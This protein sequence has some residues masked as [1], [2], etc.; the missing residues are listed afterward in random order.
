MRALRLPALFALL[1][2][3]VALIAA[4]GTP[5][6]AA[7][8]AAP[9]EAAAA[10]T[11]APTEAA[12]AATAAPTEAPAATVA[13][14]VA[15]T[16]A[17]T[18]P[19]G[20][21]QLLRLATTTSTAD[22]GLLDVILP[23]FEEENNARVEVI[24]VGT[25]QALE[26][27]QN[28]DV[29]V[30]L[31]HARSREDA[32]VSEGFGTERRDVMYNDFVI[33]GPAAD[34]AKIADAASAKDAFAAIAAAE[35]PFASRGDDSGTHSKEKS[36]WAS[37]T[38]TPTAEMSWYRSLGQG[39]GET[40]LTADQLGAYTLTDRGT[41]LSQKENLP[42]LTL[43]FG[44]ETI[45]ENPD[46]ALYNPYGVIPVN[47]ERHEGI[48]AELAEAFAVW[49]TSPETA[50]LIGEYGVDTFGQPLFYPSTGQ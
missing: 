10:P 23:V 43:L 18:A 49:I 30:V 47:P 32:F 37:A 35:A 22:S 15:A 13:P 42:G 21:E 20:G 7:P 17:A 14:T 2:L 50:T 27:G 8:T 24:A 40:L 26:L 44:G 25:G 16:V 34:P 38:I 4:C 9:T 46:K 19:A 11:A 48:N 31:V 29:D 6:A 39:M 3:F 33:V 45:A 41:W 36:I 28:G 1:A 5:P 12:P